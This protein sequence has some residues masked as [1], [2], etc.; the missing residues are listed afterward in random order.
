VKY[1]GERRTSMPVLLGAHTDWNQHGGLVTTSF[2]SRV[3]EAAM[4]WEVTFW[5]LERTE[6]YVERSWRK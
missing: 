4:T 2:P 6:E 5:V 1:I 3:C